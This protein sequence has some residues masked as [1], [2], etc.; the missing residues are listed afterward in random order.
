MIRANKFEM[1]CRIKR[2]QIRLEIEKE[3]VDLDANNT[4][5]IKA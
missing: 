4:K 3:Q 5:R 2:K 1:L